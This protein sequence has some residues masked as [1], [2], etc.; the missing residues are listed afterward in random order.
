ML[1]RDT[2]AK[3]LAQYLLE[4]SLCALLQF[5]RYRGLH[6]Y[7]ELATASG[8]QRNLPLYLPKSEMSVGNPEQKGTK[9]SIKQI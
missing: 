6:S 3:H 7:L 5:K 2:T 9:G 4:I 1:F 8:I